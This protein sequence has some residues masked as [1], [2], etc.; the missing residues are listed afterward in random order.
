MASEARISAQKKFEDMQQRQKV[1]LREEEIVLNATREKTARLR[2]LRL[3]KEE[4]DQVEK[5][6]ISAEKLSAKAAKAKKSR[7]KAAS[8][9]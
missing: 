9:A 6:R 8:K 3:A 2:E 4:K 5:D 7:A 1:A